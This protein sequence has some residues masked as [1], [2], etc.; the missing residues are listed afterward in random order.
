MIKRKR[1]LRNNKKCQFLASHYAALLMNETWQKDFSL[2][3][4]TLRIL[5]GQEA[6][7]HQRYQWD[8]ITALLPAEDNSP[9]VSETVQHNAAFLCRTFE[10]MKHAEKMLEFIIVMSSNDGLQHV[11]Q[12][13]TDSDPMVLERTLCAHYNITQDDFNNILKTLTDFQLLCASSTYHLGLLRLSGR[14]ANTLTALKLNEPAELLSE[15][16]VQSPAAKFTLKQFEHVDVQML[17]RYL[18]AAIK[19][20]LKGINI[21]LYGEPGTGKTELARTLAK[22]INRQLLE[23]RSAHV[24]EGHL[25]DD[26]GTGSPS[27]RRLGSM[28]MLQSLLKHSHSTLLLVDECEGLFDDI[29]TVYTKEAF[30]RLLESNAVPAIWITNHVELLE[31]SFVRRFKLVM[32]L[33][34]PDE[35][36]YYRMNKPM[37]SPLNV[38]K[39]FMLQLAGRCHVSPAVIANAIHIARTLELQGEEAETLIDSVIASTQKASGKEISS[40]RYQ[41]DIAFDPALFNLKGQNADSTLADIEFA[42]SEGLPVRVLLSGPPGTG[43]T[44]WPHY[45]AECMGLDVLHI[46]SSDVLSKYVGDSEQKLA[47]LFRAAQQSQQ[48]ILLDEVDSILSKRESANA[49]HEVQLVN[50]LL[51]QL[52]CCQVPVFAATNHLN[53]LDSAVMRRFDF[54]LECDYLTQQQ[55]ELL[56]RQTLQLR[57]LTT[58]EQSA[59][60]K[61]AY[62][63]PGDFAIL[64]RRTM[65]QPNHNHRANAVDLLSAENNRKQVQ[66][67]IG[68]IR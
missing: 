60:A 57:K 64:A 12:Q 43:K 6:S 63:T 19:R 10:L 35:H 25:L 54:K 1:C 62:L 7:V 65:F 31:Q 61:L 30:M 59:L 51:S 33:P 29:S 34:V 9:V 22:S 24:E 52:E 18:A 2:S 66:L 13:L 47:T 49:V 32:E 14:L 23:V 28:N 5:T 42:V 3:G 4:T 44:A 20:Q 39:E 40:T 55:K 15:V 38:T 48:L 11:T 27:R 46:K 41:G 56:Y 68:F 21:L 16:T 67:P 50:E 37:L 45:L 53:A 17:Q 8:D 36:F 58:D 26:I